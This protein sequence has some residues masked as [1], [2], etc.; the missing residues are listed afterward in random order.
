MGDEAIEAT[1]IEYNCLRYSAVIDG[2]TEE[3]AAKIARIEYKLLR[4]A[5]DTPYALARWLT[6]L[7]NLR[8]DE[9]ETRRVL[10][11]AAAAIDRLVAH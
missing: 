7:S 8:L 2:G 4:R 5:P 11:L 9:F 6:C 10:R 3:S 1:I